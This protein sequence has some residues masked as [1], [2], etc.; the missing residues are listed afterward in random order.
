MPVTFG[1]E[2]VEIDD[3]ASEDMY[4]GFLAPKQA[5]QYVITLRH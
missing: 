5:F 1:E 4:P 3:L 2:K